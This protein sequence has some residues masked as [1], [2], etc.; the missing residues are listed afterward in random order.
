MH[1]H[2]LVTAAM[3]IAISDCRAEDNCAPIRAGIEAK[4]R[5]AGT[6]NFTLSTVATDAHVAGKVV[7][8]CDR[9]AKKIV[10]VQATAATG[11]APA[12]APAPPSRDRIVTE[13]KDGSVSVGGDC[14]TK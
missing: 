6:A 9:G 3:L 14:R 4:I 11:G 10:Y 5:A 12:T 13:C 7:G 2:L 8:S 1:R